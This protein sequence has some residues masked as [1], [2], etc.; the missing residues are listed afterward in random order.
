MYVCMYIKL[1]NLL[2]VYKK[3]VKPRNTI[4]WK[5]N[6]NKPCEELRLKIPFH[7]VKIASKEDTFKETLAETL[8]VSIFLGEVF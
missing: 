3:L 6:F 8:A 5:A 7:T 1:R 4:L 2:K